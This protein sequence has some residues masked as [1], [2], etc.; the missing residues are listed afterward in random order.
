MSVEPLISVIIPARNEERFLPATLGALFQSEYPKDQFEILLIDN[1]S[2]DA[3]IAIAKSF[4]VTVLE[5]PGITIAALRNRGA[6]SARGNFLAFLD[7]DCVPSPR[8][9]K[10]IESALSSQDCLTGGECLIPE[11][12]SWIPRA[13]FCLQE[14]SIKAVKSIGSANLIIPKSR[15]SELGGFD[16]SL[17]TGEDTELCL[18]ASKII[19]VISNPGI[20]VVHFGVPE[21][22]SKFF[23]RE[24][25][26]GMGALGT[27]KVDKI[28]LPLLAS[29]LYGAGIT[30]G[31][32]LLFS[33]FIAEFPYLYS[34]I[35][36]CFSFAIAG[37]CSLH[38]RA[39]WRG[40]IHG[41]Q[42]FL[43]FNIYL[44]ARF[45]AISKLFLGASR[46]KSGTNS[47]RQA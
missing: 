38:R 15:F 19:P 7:A 2:T 43:L 20:S 37:L 12:V 28:D 8:W 11:T 26:H 9:L 35:F 1:G 29:L 40:Y 47:P 14:K 33:A 22:I 13:W 5:C 10:E 16:E 17:I 31:V 44:S 6:T 4:G 3:T 36:I 46:T 27:F 42:L 18:R 21:T 45:V 41:M 34:C 32:L 39:Y 30:L 23:R 24:I 25:W